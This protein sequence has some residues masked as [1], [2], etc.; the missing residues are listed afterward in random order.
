MKVREA[1]YKA[2]TFLKVLYAEEPIGELGVEEIKF[3]DSPSAPCWRVT[4]GFI[5]LWDRPEHPQD[6]TRFYKEIVIRDSD[7]EVVELRDRQMELSIS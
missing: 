6:G 5:R 1:V 4:V 7:K 2:R 3:D